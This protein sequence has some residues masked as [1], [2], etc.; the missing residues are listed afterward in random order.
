M[1]DSPM[2]LPHAL[3]LNE[4]SR[5]SITGVS[6]VVSFDENTVVLHTSVGTLNIHGQ[7]LQ[8]KQLS[9]DGGQ[10]SVDGKVSALIY[11]E[12]RD[13]HGWLHRLLR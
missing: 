11:E 8:L 10:V 12:P 2:A 5:L 3:T 13:S 4:R 9:P 1:T 7:Q 6:E